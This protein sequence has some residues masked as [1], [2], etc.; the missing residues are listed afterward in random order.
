MA[1]YFTHFLC[2]LDVG[3]PD[4]AARALD[5]YNALSLEGAEEDP[6][7]DS[8]LLSIQP[9]HG[10]TQLW[11]RDEATGDPSVSSTSCWCAPRPSASPAVGAFNG[12]TPAR[13]RA[14]TPSQAARMCSISTPA[15]PLHGSA[16]IAGS[17]RCSTQDRVENHGHPH[18][19]RANFNTLLRAAKDG[20]LALMECTDCYGRIA[21]WRSVRHAA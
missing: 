15:R 20:S 14:S 18:H 12:P 2:L 11:M 8:F 9:E 4:N 21:W 10:G 13:A 5:L 1:D 16:R 17:P 19:A 3:T 6:P 7:S